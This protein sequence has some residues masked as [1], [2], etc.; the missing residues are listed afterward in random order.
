MHPSCCKPPLQGV[1]GAAG[2]PSGG[3]GAE[4]ARK[5]FHQDSVAGARRVPSG[6]RACQHAMPGAMR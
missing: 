5:A 3:A 2:P 4:P 6:C 1:W